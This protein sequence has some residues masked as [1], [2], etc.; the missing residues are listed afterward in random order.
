MESFGIF[1]KAFELP[2]SCLARI[3]QREVSYNKKY[4][5]KPDFKIGQ[6]VS[7]KIRRNDIKSGKILAERVKEM[8]I[9]T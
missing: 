2:F 5:S 6:R 9:D 7:F 1:I 8:D 4:I 3:K